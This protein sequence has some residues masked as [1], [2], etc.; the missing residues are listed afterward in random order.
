MK[1]TIREM[2]KTVQIVSSI[3]VNTRS[4]LTLNRSF[5][6]ATA[7]LLISFKIHEMR[8]QNQK[9]SITDR[10]PT[11]KQTNALVKISTIPNIF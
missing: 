7:T 10:L 5:V 11:I 8:K 4:V 3:I 2:N 1:N 6:I 9:P